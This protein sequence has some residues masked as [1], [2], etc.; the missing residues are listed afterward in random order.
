MYTLKKNI[1]EK[2]I[3]FIASPNISFIPIANFTLPEEDQ[4]FESIIYSEEE[5]N[6]E[7]REKLIE[8]YRKEGR[9]ALPP[10]DKRFR[11]DS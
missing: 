2:K 11:R 5:P 6:K 9:D 8:Q 1:N 10:P 3:T 7:D 4:G